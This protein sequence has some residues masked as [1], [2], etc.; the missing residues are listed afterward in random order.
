MEIAVDFEKYMPSLSTF[1]N[2]LGILKTH[3]F[4]QDVQIIE[5]EGQSTLRVYRDS[6]DII[7]QK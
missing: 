4:I 6:D 1:Y 2:L 3:A 7:L 5:N